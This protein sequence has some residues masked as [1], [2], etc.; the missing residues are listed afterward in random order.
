[1]LSLAI[2]RFVV[3]HSNGTFMS[4]NF[5]A[6]S[7]NFL[8]MD[9]GND[10]EKIGTKYVIDEKKRK[11]LTLF[12]QYVAA[13][14]PKFV[15]QVQFAGGDELEVLIHP[16]GVLPVMAFLKGHHSA[17]FTNFIFACGLDVPTRK[18]RFEVIYALLSHRFNAR[19]RV[20]TYTDEVAPIDSITPIF[21]GAEWYEREI[22]DMYGVWFNNH[23]D[24]RRI[25]TDYGFE[26]HPQRKDFPLSGYVELRWDHELNRVIYEPTEMTQEFRKFDLNTPWEVFPAFRDESIT[27]GYNIIQ[28]AGEIE[29]KKLDDAS[30]KP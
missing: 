22:Y 3:Q 20:R 7:S 8:L 29:A 28:K 16:T 2:R 6:T 24:L 12:G 18:N 17:Q 10:K 23:P 25:L 1:M 30:K 13:C 4:T 26:G 27:S 5:V 11:K 19:I 15:Q 21:S 14:M 9:Q